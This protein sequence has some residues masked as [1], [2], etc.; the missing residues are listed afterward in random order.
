M[1]EENPLDALIILLNKFKVC[2]PSKSNNE[3]SEI[4]SLLIFLYICKNEQKGTLSRD[5]EEIIGL[6]QSSMSRNLTKL[7]DPNY[8]YNKNGRGLLRGIEDPYERR[9]KK[10]F[11][12]S[13]GEKL[14]NTIV[15]WRKN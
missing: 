11:L 8:I 15:E 6:R 3:W 14:K 10:W 13:K 5:L 2:S 1:T 9:R 4:N 12:T 7:S